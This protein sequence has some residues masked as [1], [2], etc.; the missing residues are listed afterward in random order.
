M[1]WIDGEYFPD[2]REVAKK[3]KAIAISKSLVSGALFMI[4][5]I[6][7]GVP[8]DMVG[9]LMEIPRFQTSMII[10]QPLFPPKF[11]GGGV[12]IPR[13]SSIACD[14]ISLVENEH[15]TVKVSD[16]KG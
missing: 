16:V 5:L 8:L 15:F 3:E 7:D 1:M 2:M 10:N 13:G 12:V 11:R 6:K 4:D 9:E 14:G